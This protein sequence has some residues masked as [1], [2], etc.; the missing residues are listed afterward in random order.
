MTKESEMS[1]SENSPLKTGIWLILLTIA[2]VLTTF[3]LACVTPLAAFG[4]LAALHMK[5]AE[6][7][8]L[9]SIVWLA[10]QVIG[11]GYLHYPYTASTVA[12]GGAFL[13]SALVC[14]ECAALVTR[15]MESAPNVVR[16]VGALVASMVVFKIAIYLFGMELGGNASAFKMSVVTN[17]AWTNALT[18]VVLLVLYHIGV[19][20]GLVARSSGPQRLTA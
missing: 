10:S 5:R 3:A 19:A 6:A 16:A 2:S 15:R 8:M 4:A 20:V 13:I 9:M 1:V 14:M 11:V 18:F 17:Y 7:V 12:W